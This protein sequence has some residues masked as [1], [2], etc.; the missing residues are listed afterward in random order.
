MDT[1]KASDIV[2]RADLYPRLKPNPAKI[3]EYSEN[4]DRLP[5][6]EVSD[7]GILIDGFHRWKA[8]ETCKIEDIPVIVTP[9]KSERDIERLS[10]LRNSSHGQQLTQEEKKKFA[11][12]WWDN[13]PP[14]EIC[15]ALSISRKTYDRWTSASVGQFQER[16]YP[17]IVL[18]IK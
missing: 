5:P 13:T 2:F 14:D 18:K 3:Q 9:V 15:Q 16:C 1:I 11:V 12:R 17:E 7:T 8:F 10:V 6:I 4:I